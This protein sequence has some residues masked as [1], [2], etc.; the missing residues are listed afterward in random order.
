MV[1]V[2]AADFHRCW[3]TRRSSGHASGGGLREGPGSV[4]HRGV[5]NHDPGVLHNGWVFCSEPSRRNHCETLSLPL[6]A[7]R[8]LQR[9]ALFALAGPR[10]F[11]LG[12][13][14]KDAMGGPQKSQR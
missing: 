9:I 8:S 5:A 6:Q 7:F 4:V 1:S 10:S 11:R 14:P 3:N 12:M 2:S 13:A